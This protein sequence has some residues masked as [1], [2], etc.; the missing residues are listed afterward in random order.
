MALPN[1]TIE[2]VCAVVGFTA[3]SLL[4]DWFGGSNIYVPDEANERHPLAGLI[5][6][7]AM[8]ALCREY[9]NLTLWIPATA[10]VDPEAKLKKQVAAMLCAGQGSLAIA[11]ATGMGQR[12]VQR[13]R[14]TLERY[15]M[16]PMLLKNRSKN[17][18]GKTGQP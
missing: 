16:V 15:G 1:G 8:R 2:D 3:T 10:S 11:N 5:G 17:S 7:P 9:G 18:R 6:L 13:L 12:R 14:Y 4:I